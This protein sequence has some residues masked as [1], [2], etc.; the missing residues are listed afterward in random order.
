MNKNPYGLISLW[1]TGGPVTQIIFVVLLLMSIAC[2]SIIL[3]KL[4]EFARMRKEASKQFP[5]LG[6]HVREAFKRYQMHAPRM[7]DHANLHDWLSRQN[8][9]WLN[10]LS[11]QL[12][13][14]VSVLSTVA[15]TAPFVGLLGTV[16]GIYHALIEIGFSG[17]ASLG[18]VAGPVG[19]ALI[20][21]ALGLGVAIPAAMGNNLIVKLQRNAMFKAQQFSTDLTDQLLLKG[22]GA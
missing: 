19:E 21:T 1:Q 8:N 16:W 3:A 7:A 6:Q 5:A 17:Q 2:W 18:Q 22:D 9:Q 20:M 4:L 12:Q 13:S 14:K 10:T 11:H 15:A